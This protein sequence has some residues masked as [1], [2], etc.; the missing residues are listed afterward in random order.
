MTV[1]SPPRSDQAPPRPCLTPLGKFLLPLSWAPTIGWDET[2]ASTPGSSPDAP[3]VCRRR[4][5]DT[6]PDRSVYSRRRRGTIPTSDPVL[7]RPRVADDFSRPLP[8][9]PI[10]EAGWGVPVAVGTR[11]L[12]RARGVDART[13]EAGRALGTPTRPLTPSVRSPTTP[14]PG[15]P[16]QWRARRL[17][18]K[19]GS[20]QRC[21][22]RCSL[23]RASASKNQS[24]DGQIR[25][26]SPSRSGFPQLGRIRFSAC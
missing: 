21:P 20:G 24:A 25:G 19:R 17:R 1:P 13:F 4:W 3:D 9:P 6:T 7:P 2:P 16:S 8:A 10:D 14:S 15:A 18:T 23:H 22:Q 26:R 11:A 12:G 5:R